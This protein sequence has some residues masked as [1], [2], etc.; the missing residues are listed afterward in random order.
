MGLV[1]EW[2]QAV[3]GVR[4]CCQVDEYSSE[5]HEVKTD[6]EAPSEHLLPG[7]F[8]VQ[9][10][11]KSVDVPL[12]LVEV[13][14]Q[15]LVVAKP[16]EGIEKDWNSSQ[17][18]DLNF[19]VGQCDRIVSVNGESTNMSKMFFDCNMSQDLNL[20]VRHPKEIS[21]SL[22]NPMKMLGLS[23]LWGS[24]K[25]DMRITRLER[26][27]VVDWNLQHPEDAIQVG[28]RIVS[29]NKTRRD[30]TKMLQQLANQRVLNLIVMRVR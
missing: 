6:V 8:T 11:R 24:A 29:V 3:L 19:V 17:T 30:A 1:H 12:F 15:Q 23:V 16:L 9:L 14:E 25:A 5:I 7:D 4:C 18:E 2:L 28:D 22:D 21:V 20:V 26:G 10:H 13:V 27:I